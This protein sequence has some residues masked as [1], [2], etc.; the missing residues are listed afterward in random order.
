M[1]AQKI[2]L[3]YSLARNLALWIGLFFL[4]A[5]ILILVWAASLQRK[6]SIGAFRNLASSNA[7]FFEDLRYP[8]SPHLAS[9]LS[10]ILDLGVGFYQK[11][12]PLQNIP[13]SFLPHI[14]EMANMATP[15][16][17]RIEGK[18]VAVAPFTN[19]PLYLVLVRDPPKSISLTGLSLL[20]PAMVLALGCAALAFAL[21][22]NIVK[23]LR[24]LS[25]WLPHLPS[26][27]DSPSPEIPPAILKRKDEIGVLAQTLVDTRDTLKQERELRISA[28]RLA[29][30][31]RVATSLAHEVKNPA[32]AIRMHADLMTEHATTDTSQSIELIKEE[33]DQISDLVNQWL[34]VAKAR[35]AKFETHDLNKLTEAIADRFEAQAEFAGVEIDRNFQAAPIRV[36]VDSRRIEQLIRNL[37]QNAIE[38]MPSGG[39]VSLKT[40]T[41]D[42][43]FAVLTVCDTGPGFSN[44]ALKRFGEPFFTEKEGGMGIGL[45]LSKE[46]AEAHG[47]SV[48]AANQ[49]HSPGALVTLTLPLSASPKT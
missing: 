15:T 29:A 40:E 6:E 33:V 13:A 22:L 39:V 45:T 4:V 49:R 19:S 8:L 5:A 10:G 38:A 9:Q 14:A 28:E 1:F 20:L 23:P 31:G 30:L 41:D 34:Y 2:S 25:Q 21:G 7:A 24:T 35:P 44:E 36:E 17:R 37:I 11:N 48:V 42:A 27:G 26:E 46:V 16:A 32:A 12:S 18:Q 3:N 43:G 47:G